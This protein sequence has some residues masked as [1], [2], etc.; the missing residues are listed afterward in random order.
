MSTT[1]RYEFELPDGSSDA[2][3]LNDAL[4]KLDALVNCVVEDEV[5]SEP[6]SPSEGQAWIATAG[7]TWGSTTVATND[8]VAYQL[9]T[10]R[11]YTPIDGQLALVID[12]TT[13]KKFVSGSWSAA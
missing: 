7:G 13:L 1:N 11:A 3:K 6:G 2:E 4:L 5:A 8:I 12:V 9:G 10:W